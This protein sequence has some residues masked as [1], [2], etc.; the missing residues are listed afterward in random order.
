MSTWTS[1]VADNYTVTFT[2]SDSDVVSFPKSSIADVRLF[3]DDTSLVEVVIEDSYVTTLRTLYLDFNSVATP[4]EGSAAGL[5]AAVNGLVVDGGTPDNIGA[6]PA[7]VTATESGDKDFHKTVLS[8]ADLDLG[9]I[10]AAA[11]E[12]TGALVYTLPAGDIQVTGAYM[13]IALTNADGNIDADTPD[14]G[15][16]TTVGSG[17]NALLSAVGAAAENIITG[18]TAADVTGTATLA[19]VD[20]A[21]QIP[22]A[23]DHTVYLNIADT[24]AGAETGVIANGTITLIWRFVG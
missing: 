2:D 16:G 20:A 6:V 14:V 17:A 7:G 3:A 12:S 9:A 24:W 4:S 1:V 10:A 11:A 5:L 21:L 22:A 13:S 23:N 15:V 18:Q 8:I 19:L